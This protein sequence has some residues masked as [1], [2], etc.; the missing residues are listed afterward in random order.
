MSRLRIQQYDS[1]EEQ[2][3]LIEDE[4]SVHMAQ[5]HRKIGVVRGGIANVRSP[6]YAR[7]RHGAF[8]RNIHIRFTLRFQLRQQ[9]LGKAHVD[10][11][12]KIEAQ[13]TIA[14]ETR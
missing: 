5:A 9:S 4:I 14:I 3:A 8:H 10:A 11:T 6:R 13:G 1:I 2:T 12:R 7:L